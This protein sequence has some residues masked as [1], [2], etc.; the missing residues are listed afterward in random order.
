MDKIKPNEIVKAACGNA[1]VREQFLDKSTAITSRPLTK[2]RE[3][4]KMSKL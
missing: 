4:E 1:H 3:T 2:D